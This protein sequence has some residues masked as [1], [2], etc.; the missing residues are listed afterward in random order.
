M[1]APTLSVLALLLLTGVTAA[2][3]PGVIERIEQAGGWVRRDED[4][5]GAPVT[6]ARI[7]WGAPDGEL[8]GLCELRGLTVLHLD[9]TCVTDA[10][11]A[12]VTEL[13]GLYRLT[14]CWTS[15][16]DAGLRHLGT[17]H[18]LAVL[19]LGGCRSVT[20]DGLRHLEGMKG[21]QQLLLHGC[22]KVTDEGV[23]RLRKALPHCDVQR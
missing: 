11:L 7:A 17:M 4:K 20:D 15:V 14:L 3:P 18:D 19:D 12:G 23:A 22:P 6:V 21:L 13:R 9:G 1:K 10:G 5:P 2:D 8:A 16:S